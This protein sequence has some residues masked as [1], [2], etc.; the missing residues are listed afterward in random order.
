M[1]NVAVRLEWP[2]KRAPRVV[3]PVARLELER[4]GHPG[5]MLIHGDNAAA[6]RALEARTGPVFTLVYLDPPFFTGRQ[7][8]RVDRRRDP[9]TGDVIRL[10]KPAFDD[11]WEG[12]EHYLT[13]LAERIELARKLLTPDGCLVVH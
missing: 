7:H 1:R 3:P 13:E 8:A 10:L 12:L 11:R 5:T 4:P 9:L 6:M 2:G